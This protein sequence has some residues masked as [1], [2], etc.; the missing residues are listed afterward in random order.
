M[1]SP[2]LRI[3]AEADRPDAGER[4]FRRDTKRHKGLHGQPQTRSQVLREDVGR[5][6]LGDECQTSIVSCADEDWHR[7]IEVPYLAYQLLQPR[8]A[9]QEGDHHCGRIDVGCLKHPAACCITE[10]D[11][12][13]LSMGNPKPVDVALAVTVMVASGYIWLERELIL[14]E[15][16]ESRI[17]AVV[18]SRKKEWLSFSLYGLGVPTAFISP[19]IAIALYIGVSFM[20]LIPD[21]RF[22]RWHNLQRSE[23]RSSASPQ[24]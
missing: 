3:E 12:M 17:R 16:T 5:A 19:W 22:E 21:R 1:Q 13:L 14:A 9:V 2:K 24:S 15:G 7:R 10:N 11:L 23:V 8:L 20:W 18:G 4:L 6:G